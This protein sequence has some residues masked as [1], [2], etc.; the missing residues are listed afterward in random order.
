[1]QFIMILRVAY[2]CSALLLY[3][4]VWNICRFY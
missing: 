4:V 3:T 1:M 2:A